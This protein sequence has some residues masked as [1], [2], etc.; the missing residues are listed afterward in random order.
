[1]VSLAD[2]TRQSFPNISLSGRW[3]ANYQETAAVALATPVPASL[4][5]SL[6]ISATTRR[7]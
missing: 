5:Q 3:I 6:I 1:M 4:I 7:R 2:G